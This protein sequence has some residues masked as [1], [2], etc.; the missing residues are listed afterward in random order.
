MAGCRPEYFP[1]VLASVRAVLQPEFHVG[2]TACTTGGAAPVVI[3]NGPIAE[4][5]GIS[6]GTAC[7]GGNIKPN[8]TNR[9]A[10]PPVMRNRGGGKPDGRGKANQA[11]PRKKPRC[12]PR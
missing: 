1:V 10:L 7:F 12:L 9:R 2:S 4:R 5:L 6:G 8:A 11:G 3:V